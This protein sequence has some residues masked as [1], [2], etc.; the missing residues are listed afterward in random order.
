M[1]AEISA[2]TGAVPKWAGILVCTLLTAGLSVDGAVPMAGAS[3]W[4]MTT[5]V[6]DS[7]EFTP[8]DP[9]SGV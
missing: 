7:A 8:S 1:R 9:G 6:P 4:I 2:R 5:E 3:E